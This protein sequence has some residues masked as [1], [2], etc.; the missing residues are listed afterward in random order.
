MGR[1]T[2]LELSSTSQSSTSPPQHSRK[3]KRKPPANDAS[4]R[5]ASQENPNPSPTHGGK[6][7]A[8][9]ESPENHMTWKSYETDGGVKWSQRCNSLM[10]WH[11]QCH[12]RSHLRQIISGFGKSSF[13]CN[14][15]PLITISCDRQNLASTGQHRASLCNVET[16][17]AL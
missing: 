8:R 11:S 15:D 6:P 10:D 4:R 13:R 12:T 7:I 5:Q 16:A 1:R 14:K 17:V 9:N 2:H 3:A